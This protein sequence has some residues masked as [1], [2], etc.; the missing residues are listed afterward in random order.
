MII[1]IAST[2]SMGFRTQWETFEAYQ[3]NFFRLNS[4]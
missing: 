1:S 3:V 2:F 4:L